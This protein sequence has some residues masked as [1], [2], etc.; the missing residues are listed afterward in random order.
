MKR[1][2]VKA[3]EI[4]DKKKRSRVIEWETRKTSRR[5]IHTPVDV[6]TPHPSASRLTPRRDT[7]RI[8]K[9]EATLHEKTHPYMDVEDTHWMEE[10]TIPEKK[11][12][13]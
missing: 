6:T 1:H 12:V 10:P 4:F 8:V 5:I 13:S 2:T 3:S 7:G 11:T 9:N